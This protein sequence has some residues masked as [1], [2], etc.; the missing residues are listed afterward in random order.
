M[1]MIQRL[2][3][4]LGAISLSACAG[5]APAAPKKMQIIAP[6]HLPQ[7][8][9]QA[10]NS[11]APQQALPDMGDGS[12]SRGVAR[13]EM[14]TASNDPNQP[15]IP[16]APKLPAEAYQPGGGLDSLDPSFATGDRLSK[17]ASSQTSVPGPSSIP[18]ARPPQPQPPR[19]QTTYMPNAAAP[20]VSGGF[21][22]HLASYRETGAARKGWDVYTSRYGDLLAQ[23]NPVGAN[24]SIPN[25]GNFVRLLAGPFPNQQA[26]QSVCAALSARQEYCRVDKFQ[27][28]PL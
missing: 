19:P 24:V 20:S 6:R 21:A 11:P 4:L 14:Q 12:S 26:A 23:L 22:I 3:F 16:R 18:S 7:Q 9:V 28:V 13:P 2:I 8:L 10:A 25:K 1:G 27:G 17:S 15:E 5:T